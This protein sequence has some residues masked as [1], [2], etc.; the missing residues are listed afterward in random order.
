MI[1]NI[2]W[3]LQFQNDFDALAEYLFEKWGEKVLQEVY[4]EILS[5]TNQISKMPE[6]FPPAN[7]KKK[8][9]YAVVT[10]Q[11]TIIYKILK[12]EI[13][14]VALFDTRQNPDKKLPFTK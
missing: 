14:L 2:I 11:T 13:V 4:D 6:M 10:K 5:I 8:I 12:R 9:R 3:S 7:K 1:M